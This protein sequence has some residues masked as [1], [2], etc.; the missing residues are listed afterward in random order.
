MVNLLKTVATGLCSILL[1]VSMAVM[2]WVNRQTTVGNLV[3]PSSTCFLLQWGGDN[4][5]HSLYSSTFQNWVFVLNINIQFYR[6]KRSYTDLNRTIFVSGLLCNK[7]QEIL[8][9]YHQKP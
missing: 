3:L 5:R 2:V 9:E 1:L 7:I 6:N 8:S 4:L